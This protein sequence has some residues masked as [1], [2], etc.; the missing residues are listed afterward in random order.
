MISLWPCPSSPIPSMIMGR[1]D[2]MVMMTTDARMSRVMVEKDKTLINLL[3]LILRAQLFLTC[4]N[5]QIL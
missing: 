5:I 3:D 2:S 1:T 4:S